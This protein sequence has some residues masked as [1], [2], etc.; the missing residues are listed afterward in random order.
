MRARR[1]GYDA[2]ETEG[3]GPPRHVA[4][5]RCRGDIVVDATAR[6]DM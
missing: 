5:T 6:E 3:D 4:G 1:G 2:L